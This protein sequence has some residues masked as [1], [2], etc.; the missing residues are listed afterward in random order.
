[1]V[2]NR[3]AA[4]LSMLLLALAPAAGAATASLSTRGSLLGQQAAGIT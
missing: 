1:M 3:S 4:V 2:R